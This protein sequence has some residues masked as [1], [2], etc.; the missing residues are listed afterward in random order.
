MLGSLMVQAG[1]PVRRGGGRPLA[2]GGEALGRVG[3]LPTAPVGQ[4]P[5]VGEVVERD[6]GVDAA[7]PKAVAQPGVVVEGGDRP[8]AV[9]GLDAAP[10]QREAVV[11]EPQGLHD[12]GVIGPAVPRVAGV[13]ARFDHSRAGGVLEGPPV[14]VPVAPLDLVGGR[15][16]PQVN[17]SGKRRVV[18]AAASAAE[19]S[20]M[21][22]I[23]GAAP[24][25]TT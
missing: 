4:P 16:V 12:V 15:A 6:H 24:P 19:G 22:R 25:V 8:L 20:G 7:V 2:E 1:D 14:V 10:L 18:D 5:G 17:P 11:V 3:R 21:V 9:F 23:V 13:A